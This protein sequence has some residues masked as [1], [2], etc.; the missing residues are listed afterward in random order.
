MATE[1]A[2]WVR[3]NLAPP[4]SVWLNLAGREWTGTWVECVVR[5]TPAAER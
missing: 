1:D 2:P 3:V 5:W 4:P